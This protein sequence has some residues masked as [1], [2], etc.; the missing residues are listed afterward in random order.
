MPRNVS[1]KVLENRLYKNKTMTQYYWDATKSPIGQLY[2]GHVFI[3]Y[4]AYI[5]EHITQ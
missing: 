4:F 1:Q 2:V 5:G 3:G